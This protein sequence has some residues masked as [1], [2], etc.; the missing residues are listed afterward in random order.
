MEARTIK[1]PYGQTTTLTYYESGSNLGLLKRVTESG[2][3]YLEFSYNASYL[4]S[5]VDANDGRGN[6]IDWVVYHY[7][8]MPPGGGHPSVNCLTTVDY[9]DDTHAKYTY[10]ED[11]VPEDLQN[12]SIKVFPLVSG[13]DDRRYDGPMRRIAY[14]Y[15]DRGPHGAIRQERYWDG[16]P[17]SEGTGALVSK[18]EPD[19]PSPITYDPNFE[20]TYTETRGD[21]NVTRRFT[22]TELHLARSHSETDPCPRVT[23]GPAPQQFLQTYTDFKIPANSTQLGYDN[24]WYV[25][26]VTDANNHRVDYDRGPSPY[27]SSGPKGIG[28]ITK[29]SYPAD[30]SHV[31]Y[32]YSD[33][34]PNL[35][36]HYVTSISEYTAGNQLRSQTIHQRDPTTHK[37]YQT[38]YKGENGIQ[39]AR[40]TFTYCDQPDGNQCGPANPATGQMH[41]QIKTHQLKNGA[42]V[43]YRYDSL[44]RGLLTDKWEPT[45]TLSASETEPKTHYDYYTGADGKP[46][47]IGR[48]MKVTGPRPNWEYASRRPRPMNTTG[49]QMYGLCRAGVGDNDHPCRQQIAVV[50]IQSVGK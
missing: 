31:D 17:G 1:D 18:I 13:C 24:N 37:I 7:T 19:A 12:G 28:Q 25:N 40:E 16:V 2:G 23:R 21:G 33:E 35:S 47:W 10:T 8:P 50:R 14:V 6:L 4:V 39:L 48:V 22:Y 34:S 27:A 26:S 11:N 49:S 45:S 42:Y 43:H 3:R 29:I 30:G 32:G 15:Q 36:G 9:S 38:D 20:T 46:G 5:R 44:G 41:G